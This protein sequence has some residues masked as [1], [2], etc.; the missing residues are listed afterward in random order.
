MERS[1]GAVRTVCDIY[2]LME[3]G[4]REAQDDMSWK[5]MIEN[6]CHESML[7]TG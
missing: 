1:S 5:K 3:G 4:A 7:Y 6:D 2:W